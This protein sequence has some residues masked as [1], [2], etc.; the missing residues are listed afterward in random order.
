MNSIDND[1]RSEYDPSLFD[2][3]E[4][5]KYA[6]RLNEASNVVVLAPDVTQAFPNAQAVND[7]LRQLIKL[8][9]QVHVTGQAI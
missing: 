6:Q 9:Q 4:V 7:A 2:N 8:V 5:G 3:A 1:M